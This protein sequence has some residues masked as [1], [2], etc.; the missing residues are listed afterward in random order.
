MNFIKIFKHPLMTPIKAAGAM[1]LSRTNATALATLHTGQKLRVDLGSTVGRSIYLRGVYEHEVENCI[2]RCL[3]IGDTFID[4]GSNVGYF[5]IIASQL[6]GEAGFV[7]AFEPHK[8]VFNLLKESVKVNSANNVEI[9]E[10]ALWDE[11]TELSFEDKL[12]SAF[13]YITPH[14]DDSA[15][16]KIQAMT[17]DDYISTKKLSSSVKLIKIDVEGAEFKVIS[18][19]KETIDRVHPDFII[20]LQNWSLSRFSSE[21]KD[22]VNFFTTRSYST[23]N[24]SHVLLKSEEEAMKTL[25]ES[26]VKNLLFKRD[27]SNNN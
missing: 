26:A 25:E 22:I 20:E 9:A 17:F 6:V 15:S 14:R 19:M 23:Y 11:K 8:K 27:L 3:N 4:V 16:S 24:L 12:N 21:I 7:Y 1:I 5:S 13:S 2:R 18:G 10:I